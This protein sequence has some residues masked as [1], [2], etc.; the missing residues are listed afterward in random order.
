MAEAGKEGAEWL[1]N[2][3]NQYFY[4]MLDIARNFG[5]SN[6]RFG[7]DAL[8][9]FFE[10][11]SHPARAVAAAFAMQKNAILLHKD[12]EF[13]TLAGQLYPEALPYK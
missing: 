13:D 7:G 10:G 1:T 3:I 6:L 8:L 12:P 9:L 2:I 11:N 5:G 4:T